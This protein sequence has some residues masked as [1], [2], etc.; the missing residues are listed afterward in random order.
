MNKRLLPAAIA[1]VILAVGA[2]TLWYVTRPAPIPTKPPA[3]APVAGSCWNV[4]DPA[5]AAM[6]WPGSAVGCTAPHTAEVIYVSQVAKELVQNQRT[7]KGDDA[8][9]GAAVMTAQ[10]RSACGAQ[11]TAYLGGTWRAAQLSVIPT[12]IT[13]ALD[14]FYACSIIR[15]GGPGGSAPVTLNA[16]LKGAL[17]GQGAADLAIQCYSEQGTALT[18]APCNSPHAGEFIGLYSVTPP[19]A[20]Y[21]GPE[22]QD[23]VAKGCASLLVTFLGDTAGQNR[24]DLQTS[25]VGPKSADTWNGSDQTYAC[26]VR[27][28]TDSV[29]LHGSLEG[30]GTRALP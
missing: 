3:A 25:S 12:F 11:A 17:A 6:P 16:S 27:P 7:A 21:N 30:I 20:P 15:T 8:R 24:S 9:I 14:G 28:V 18:Y 5:A 26:Y 2:T 1:V 4:P 23:A 10:A 13:P 22:L 19:G 29:T